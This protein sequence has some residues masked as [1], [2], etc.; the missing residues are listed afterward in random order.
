MLNIHI[1][2]NFIMLNIQIVQKP[3]RQKHTPGKTE[4]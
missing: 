4:S 3:E 2:Q 1:V